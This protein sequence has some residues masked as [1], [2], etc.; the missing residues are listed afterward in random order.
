MRTHAEGVVEKPFMDWA[1][2]GGLVEAG[3]EIGAHTA[4]HPRLA[5]LLARDG[6]YAGL[7]RKQLLERELEERV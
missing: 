6:M 7:Y 2:L 3:W 1:Q 5:E 4:T